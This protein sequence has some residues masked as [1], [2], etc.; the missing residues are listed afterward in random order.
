M[1]IDVDKW[2]QV[3]GTLIKIALTLAV[4]AFIVV[5]LIPTFAYV[6]DSLN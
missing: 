6:L 2:E 4:G 5:N 3:I 1:Y